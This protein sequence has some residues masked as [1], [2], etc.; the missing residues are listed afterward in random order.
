MTELAL[1]I[2]IGSSSVRVLAYDAKGHA[3]PALSVQRRY[4]AATTSDG[5]AEFDAAQLLE[6][7]LSCIDEACALLTADQS[8]IAVGTDTFATNLIGLDA[9]SQPLTPVYMWNDTRSRDFVSQLGLDPEAAHDRTGTYP[10]VSYWPSRLRWIK[11]QHPEICAR[12]KRWLSIGEWLHLKLFGMARVS[13][14]IAAWT[15]MLN[16]RSGQW[17]TESLRA[18]EIDEQQLSTISDVPFERL[19]GAFA[20]RWPN[21]HAA[22]W[23]PALSDGYTANIGCGCTTTEQAALTIGTSGALRTLVTY[24]PEHLPRGLFCYRV[25][26]EQSLVGG[27]VSNAGNVF[28]WLKKTLKI[29]HDPFETDAAPDSHGLTVLPFWAGERSMGWHV[30]AQAAIMGMTL[31]TAPDQIA[32]AALEAVIYDLVRIQRTLEEWLHHPPMIIAAGGVLAASPGW[33]QAA[34]DAFGCDVA[35][36]A[37][38]E[39]SARGTALLALGLQAV[40]E[41]GAVYHARPTF[42]ERYHNAMSRQQRMYD[43]MM[44]KPL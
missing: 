33:A 24:M 39:S 18:A 19:D 42:T 10:H 13:T 32:R 41:I 14:S 25:S 20:A 4:E 36:S 3:I 7:V 9:E 8:I 40:S 16:R 29:E 34:A 5:G 12:V 44:K 6:Y 15:G 43:L 31:N 35:I 37:E 11:A 28:A 22:R 38:A 2:D 26:A 23:Y 27:A 1:A 21:L 30:D 17:D